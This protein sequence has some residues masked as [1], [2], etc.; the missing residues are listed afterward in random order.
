MIA[1]GN[2]HLYS[3]SPVKMTK[4]E[5]FTDKRAKITI[6]PL[7]GVNTFIILYEVAAG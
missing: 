1:R 3:L 7:I 6:V 5:L 4:T 2:T